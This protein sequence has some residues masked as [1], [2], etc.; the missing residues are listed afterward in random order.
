MKQYTNCRMLP[1]ELDA[2]W[3]LFARTPD[4]IEAAPKEVFNDLL[5]VGRLQ[6]WTEP[7]ALTPIVAMVTELQLTDR[8][9]FVNILTFAGQNVDDNRE[10]F[11]VIQ[12]WARKNGC[13]KLRAVCK[14]AQTR[15]FA[16]DGFVKVANVIE[17]EVHDE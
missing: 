15:L 4:F 2:L 13:F 16:R 1:D 14:E 8:G 10:M 3:A 12:R 7:N 6:L 9:K 5:D 11:R 17:L